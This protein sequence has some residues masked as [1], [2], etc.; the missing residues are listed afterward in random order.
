MINT[1]KSSGQNK[2]MFYVYNKGTKQ[3]NHFESNRVAE[4]REETGAKCRERIQLEKE[5]RANDKI[6]NDRAIAE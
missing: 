1:N 2:K 3:A 6:Q 5:R 4:V